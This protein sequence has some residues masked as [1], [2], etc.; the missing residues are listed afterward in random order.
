MTQAVVRA[1]SELDDYGLED[2]TIFTLD[3][4]QEAIDVAA[5][6]EYAL[7]VG[8]ILCLYSF[9]QDFIALSNSTEE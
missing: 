9:E 7:F 3:R 2:D 4:I 1:F 8:L 5:L 6:A